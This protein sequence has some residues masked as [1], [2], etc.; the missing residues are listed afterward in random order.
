MPGYDVEGTMNR[1][2]ACDAD[3]SAEAHFCM[4]CG[5]PV[6]T[7]DGSAAMVTRSAPPQGELVTAGAVPASTRQRAAEGIGAHH[8][9]GELRTDLP[10]LLT[11]RLLRQP[12][13]H[14]SGGVSRHRCHRNT[15]NLRM[16]SSSFSSR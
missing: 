10:L 12:H 4:V 8:A 3:L 13:L 6:S 14:R 15:R 16:E 5:A 2:R 11:L 9:A 1:C 7:G